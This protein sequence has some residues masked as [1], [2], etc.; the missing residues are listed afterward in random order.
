MAGDQE[1]E[2]DETA[3][4][5]A[6]LNDAFRSTF[7]AAAGHVVAKSGFNAL[8]ENDKRTFVGL[9]QS[10]N[11]FDEENDLQDE[12][13]FGRV[14][15][16]GEEVFWKIDYYDKSVQWASPDPSDPDLTHR[17]LTLMLANEY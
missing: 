16:G 1:R 15:H 6:R 8:P 3:R 9:V 2:F 12:H 5:I 11:A 7:N 13:S 10:F 17:V 4:A 14:E